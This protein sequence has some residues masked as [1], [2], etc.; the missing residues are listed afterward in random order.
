VPPP[1]ELIGAHPWQ[2]V[3]FTTYCLSL[4]FFEA[5]VLDQLV[6]GG[7]RNALVLADVNGVRGALSE[8]GARRAGKEYDIEPVAVTTGELSL[9]VGH[10]GNR[11]G[12]I[13]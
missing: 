1:L 11:E 5:A 7:A 9:K 12:G 4:S 6:R 10:G 2:R 8:Q 3:V 13:S